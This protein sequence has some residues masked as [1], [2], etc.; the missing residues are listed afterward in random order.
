MKQIL[1]LVFLLTCSLFIHASGPS[2]NFEEISPG[3]FVHQ[4]EHLDVDEAY[5]GDI[6]NI[7]FI[8]GEKAIAVIDTGGS[9]AIGK[10][11]KNAIRKI[12]KL[13]IRYVINTHVHLDHIYGNAIFKEDD[14]DFIGHVELPRAMASRKGFYER[15]NLKYLKIPLKKSIQIAPNIL[16]KPNESESFD[17]GNRVI[18]VTGYPVSHTNTDVTVEDIKTK[19]LWAGDLLFIERT[20]VIDGDIHG[21]IAV[22]D[23][24]LKL[25]IDQVIPGHGTPTK[26]WKQA[27]LKE[28]NYFKVLRDELRLAI[29]N[30]QDLQL[31]ID[32]AGRSESKKWELFN[33]QNGRNINKIFPIMEWE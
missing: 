17:L 33:V 14:I 9:L 25:D 32:T 22:I 8:V 7:G 20:P 18:K 12:S 6:A 2:L 24:I 28:Q 21:F 19:T 5:Q 1:L 10:E 27:F 30:D 13:P 4:G 31:T 16:I 23:E 29:D 11:L 26:K 3:I 15:T